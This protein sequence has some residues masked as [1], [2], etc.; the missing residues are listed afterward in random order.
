VLLLRERGEAIET[1]TRDLSSDG[2]LCVSSTHFPPGEAL[3]C[4]IRVPSFDPSSQRRTRILECS[5]RVMRS[6]PTT[7]EGEFGVAFRIEDYHVNGGG[8]TPAA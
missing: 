6:E 5:V 4:A 1:V 7:S 8:A 3:T 2:F